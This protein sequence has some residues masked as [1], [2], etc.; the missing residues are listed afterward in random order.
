MGYERV[1]GYS[2]KIPA[3]QLGKWKTVWVIG[4]YGLYGVWVISESTVYGLESF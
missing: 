4:E 1:M 2:D 3:N